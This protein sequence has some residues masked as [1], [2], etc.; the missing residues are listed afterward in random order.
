M[1]QLL[2]LRLV[3][4][5]TAVPNGASTVS[6]EIPDSS[7]VP[8]PDPNGLPDGEG[9]ALPQVAVKIKKKKKRCSRGRARNR[10]KPVDPDAEKEGEEARLKGVDDGDAEE[11]ERSECEDEPGLLILRSDPLRAWSEPDEPKAK[12]PRSAF[13]L[14]QVD[15]LV[16]ELHKT[17]LEDVSSRPSSRNQNET[18][19]V[20]PVTLPEISESDVLDSSP[21]VLV[22]DTESLRHPVASTSEDT[23]IAFDLSM[24]AAAEEGDP[25]DECTQ[26]V[27]GPIPTAVFVEDEVQDREPAPE[28][29]TSQDSTPEM[30]SVDEPTPTVICVEEEIQD[31][32]P[33][34]ELASSQDSTPEMEIS[35]QQMPLLAV[36]STALVSES[37]HPCSELSQDILS[38]G[39]QDICPQD[40]VSGSG[41]GN[42]AQLVADMPGSGDGPQ[43]EEFESRPMMIATFEQTPRPHRPP[44]T[45]KPRLLG[46]P[47]I[48]TPAPTYMTGSIPSQV[49]IPV[50]AGG[51]ARPSWLARPSGSSVHLRLAAMGESPHVRPEPQSKL[52]GNLPPSP[53]LLLVPPQVVSPVA[54]P[55]IDSGLDRRPP[56]SPPSP[57]KKPTVRHLWTSGPAGDPPTVQDNLLLPGDS[58]RTGFPPPLSSPATC[59]S[60]LGCDSTLVSNVHAARSEKTPT[61]S[62]QTPPQRPTLASPRTL[63]DQSPAND[64]LPEKYSVASEPPHKTNIPSSTARFQTYPHHAFALPKSWVEKED[65]DFG[66]LGGSPE[67]LT[68]L[69]AAW[70]TTIQSPPIDI[71]PPHPSLQPAMPIRMPFGPFPK[72]TCPKGFLNRQRPWIPPAH[73]EII[74]LDTIEI[75]P[76]ITLKETRLPPI[77]YEQA[78][79][80]SWGRRL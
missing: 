74:D 8:H 77:Q 38:Q 41:S 42:E 62:P 14:A 53:A 40:A 31:R 68:T 4:E 60:L 28:L 35:L 49:S 12:V 5:D 71:D 26:F 44:R 69:A 15:A 67:S 30:E 17:C 32:E 55:E 70:T 37:V 64:Y 18:E 6:F 10:R 63:V 21:E 36:E 34:P 39:A 33:T 19:A 80:L 73:L 29:A 9:D 20:L 59:S 76:D 47:R 11:A 48:P 2:A 61:P 27:N 16:K 51:T 22:P 25:E 52:F 78:P 66:S 43:G 45:R 65:F 54:P 23:G 72:G 24:E 75:M 58:W 46:R 13:H 56:A 79:L 7:T 3:P 57:P 1:K 50:I